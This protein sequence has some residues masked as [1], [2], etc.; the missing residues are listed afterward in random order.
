MKG[1]SC[2]FKLFFNAYPVKKIKFGATFF[3]LKITASFFRIFLFR[4]SY[5][6]NLFAF[7]FADIINATLLD[8]VFLLTKFSGKK[9]RVKIALAKTDT[10]AASRYFSVYTSSCVNGFFSSLVKFI[11]RK[12]SFHFLFLLPNNYCVLLQSTLIL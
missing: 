8:T 3:D 4:N 2:P 5:D 10:V 6:F 7:F 12:N 9:T 1:E 11:L